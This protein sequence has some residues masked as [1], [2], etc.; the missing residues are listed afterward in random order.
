MKPLFLALIIGF[1]SLPGAAQADK[2]L[3]DRSAI[4]A[5]SR[6]FSA[7][8]VAI[9]TPDA[10]IVPTNQAIKAGEPLIRQYWTPRSGAKRK[11]VRHEIT[12]QELIIDGTI[13]ADIGYFEGASADADGKEYPFRGAYLITWRKTGGVW[14]IQHDMWNSLKVEE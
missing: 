7:A 11:P 2:E 6:S 3:H 14:R 12:S 10:R 9:Y 1:I 8:Y 4:M 5:Q 13:A